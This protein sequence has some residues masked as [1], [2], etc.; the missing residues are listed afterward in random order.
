MQLD[1]L[2]TVVSSDRTTTTSANGTRNDISRT[3]VTWADA[4]KG[5]RIADT[6]A[7]ERRRNGKSLKDRILLKQSS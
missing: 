2:A 6:G 5:V 1:P 7:K 3:Y 4:V